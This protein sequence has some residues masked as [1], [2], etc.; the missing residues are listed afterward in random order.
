MFAF[1]VLDGR[2]VT[3][4]VAPVIQET[5]RRQAAA[6][7]RRR[8]VQGKLANIA[9]GVFAAVLDVRIFTACRWVESWRQLA[10]PSDEGETVDLS[11]VM[12]RA[13]RAIGGGWTEYQHSHGA[14]SGEAALWA[15]YCGL[16]SQRLCPLCQ[17]GTG[18]PRHVIM[19]CS[20]LAALRVMVCDAVE[21]ELGVVVPFQ[22]LVEAG[23]A[24]WARVGEQD[25]VS[26]SFRAPLAAGARWPILSA[27]R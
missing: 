7:W 25:R 14:L 20:D 4:H 13:H 16:A 10:L 24:W 5:L 18:T 3:G 15:R 2:M 19:Q 23:R 9:G 21:A 12:F 22:R 8:P 6:E 1:V 17:A 26:D 27:W 11:K